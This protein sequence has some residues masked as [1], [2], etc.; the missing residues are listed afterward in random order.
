MAILKPFRALRPLPEYVKEVASRPYDV[1]NTEE[2]IKEAEGNPISFLHVVKPEIDFPPDFDPYSP[3]IYE[4][5]KENFKHLCNEGI[6]ARDKT[7]N[8]YLYML[9]MNGRQQTGIVGCA[10]SS[11][12]FNNVIK[13][14]ELTRPDKEDDRKNHIRVSGMHAEPVFFSYPGNNELELIVENIKKSK[15]IYDFIAVDGIKHAVWVIDEKALI[16]T[17]QKIFDTIPSTYIADGHHRTAA[18][19]LMSR[20]F[21]NADPHSSGNEEYN[22]FLAVHFPDHELHIMDYNR[23]VKDLNGHSR[24]EFLE[25]LSISFDIKSNGPA[26]YKPQKLHEFSMYLDGNWFV[27]KALPGSWVDDDPTG[28]LDV[29]IL[30]S[31][32]LKPVLGIEDIRKDKRIDFVGGIRG[33]SEL[34]RRVNIGEMKV[35]FALYPVSMKQLMDIAD[36]GSIMPPKTTWFEPKLRSGLFVHTF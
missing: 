36:S 2:A 23:V 29:S 24:D 33:L 9:E 35:A 22:Y 13:K 14:H 15:P 10:D 31:Q 25:L 5:G 12:Y 27:L 18:A 26:A 20:E 19:A 34:E 6:F 30:Y 3:E 32:V 11:D 7:E 1:L 21:R 8:L 28:V 17:I 4:R 16:H